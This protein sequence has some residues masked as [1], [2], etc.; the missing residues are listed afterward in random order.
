MLDVL[1]CLRG[2]VYL[3]FAYCSWIQHEEE[4]KNSVDEGLWR[5]VCGEKGLYWS[6]TWILT[7]KSGKPPNH[8]AVPMMQTEWQLD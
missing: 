1:V 3:F 5:D 2:D 4:N 6:L 8:P 7:H